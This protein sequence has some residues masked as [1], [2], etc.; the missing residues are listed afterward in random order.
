MII[1]PYSEGI[2]YLKKA[3]SLLE[4]PEMLA[5]VNYKIGDLYNSQGLPERS[6]PFYKK[7]VD[8]KPGDATGRSK[9]AEAYTVVYYLKEALDQLDTLYLHKKINFKDQLLMAEYCIHAARFTDAAALLK[10]T[11]QV[12]PINADKV[13]DLTARLQLLSNHPKEALKYYKEWLAVHPA[14]SLTMYTIARLHAKMKNKREALKW[15]KMSID[16][17]LQFYWIVK[18]DP[19]WNE[20]RSASQWI[21]ITRKLDDYKEY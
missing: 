20:Y 18:M 13:A 4:D 21:T 3:D 17:G 15:L 10:E 5:D 2:A 1:H 14:D 7:T 16:H 6:V 11:S 8:L 12:H 19:A 9:L